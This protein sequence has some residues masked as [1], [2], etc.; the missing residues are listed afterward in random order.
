M[1]L[2]ELTI[3]DEMDGVFAVSL[4]N[5]PATESEF[6]A[7]SEDK[8]VLELAEVSGEKRQVLGAALIPNKSIYRKGAD[9]EEYNIFF[10]KDTI[11]KVQENFMKDKN[12][13][14]MTLEHNQPIKGVSII[15]SWIKEGSDK[16][17]NYDMNLPDGSWVI[18][19]KVDSDEI[20]NEVKQNKVLGFSI[21]GRFTDK[22]T[23]NKKHEEYNDQLLESIVENI[24]EA[25][26][27]Y[28]N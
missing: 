4:V 15:E 10:S 1:K 21:E 6:V 9:G 23:K 27:Q 17:D 8:K 11:A 22:L 28:K 20:W 13:D 12:T 14:S 7:L 18:M 25:I 24:K 16:S 3:E 2:Y 19:A 26:N 5:T